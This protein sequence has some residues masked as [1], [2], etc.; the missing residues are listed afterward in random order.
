VNAALTTLRETAQRHGLPGLFIVG[1]RYT[2]Y[3]N[4]GCFPQCDATD[5]GPSGLRLEGYDALSEYNSAGTAVPRNGARPYSELV[6]A[7]R[8]EWRQFAQLSPVPWIPSVTVGWDP[9]PWDERPFGDLFWFTR[10]PAQVAA[11]MEDA[12]A[13]L[14]ENPSM[15]V[16]TGS[17]P[18]LVLIEAWNELGEGSYV[19]PTKQDRYAYGR[20]LASMLGLPWTA[21]HARRLAM[22]WSGIHAAGTLTVLDDWTPCDAAVVKIERKLR[23]K[24]MT[25]RTTTTRPDGTFAVTLRRGGVYRAHVLASARYY[26]TCGPALSAPVRPEPH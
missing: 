8:D 2:A 11:F 12:I 23:G 16:G 13:W 9:R 17:E 14:R 1:G 21:T 15:H 6:A 10:T 19:I 5:G 26:Q 18:P 24:W 4:I 22:T 7:V 25:A 3:G 20:A